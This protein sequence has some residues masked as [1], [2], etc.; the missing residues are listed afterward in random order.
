MVAESEHVD[1]DGNF[2]L[3]TPKQSAEFNAMLAEGM[4]LWLEYDNAQH[5]VTMEMWRA[6]TK[7]KVS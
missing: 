7:G 5:K 6:I 3:F 4:K 2:K 1:A